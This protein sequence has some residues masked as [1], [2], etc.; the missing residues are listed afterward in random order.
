MMIAYQ[1]AEAH[2]RSWCEVSAYDR[3]ALIAVGRLT[4]VGE[5]AAVASIEVH[6]DYRS[7][8]V[9]ANIVKLLLTDSRIRRQAQI[10]VA[11]KIPAANVS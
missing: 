4:A 6:P 10:R 8:A 1:K 2:D 7:R 5:G 11:E 3:D 9:E